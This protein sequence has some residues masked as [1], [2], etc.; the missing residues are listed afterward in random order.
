MLALYSQWQQSV[1]PEG[2]RLLQGRPPDHSPHTRTALPDPTAFLP[3]FLFRSRKRLSQKVAGVAPECRESKTI[4]KL[5]TPELFQRKNP[6]NTMES[7]G[8]LDSNT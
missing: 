6:S 1:G 3:R 5:G 8:R 2:D 7:T 4:L